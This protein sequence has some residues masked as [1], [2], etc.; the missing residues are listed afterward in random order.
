MTCLH[1]GS[2]CCR[3]ALF[4]SAFASRTAEGSLRLCVQWLMGTGEGSLLT[5][6]LRA[7]GVYLQY[8]ASLLGSVHERFVL[9]VPCYAH[10]RTPHESIPHSPIRFLKIHFSVFSSLPLGLPS[11]PSCFATY[12][13]Y[14]HLQPL[15]C[16]LH[17]PYQVTSSR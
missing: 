2:V 10:K 1:R 7:C 16:L 5:Y 17:G 11:C 14:M 12:I 9:K 15:P 6:K 3:T 4:L 8:P 13:V